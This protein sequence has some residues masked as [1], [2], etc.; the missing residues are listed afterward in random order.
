MTIKIP[1]LPGDDTWR[2]KQV[3][4]SGGKTTHVAW[5]RVLK[6]G[7]AGGYAVAQ[8]EF[9]PSDTLAFDT[10][11][12]EGLKRIERDEHRAKKEERDKEKFLE[13]QRVA[14]EHNDMKYKK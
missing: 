12:R 14:K 2:V 4:Y 11:Y 3:S 8:G 10:V 5:W 6:S 1:K 9:F 7:S 13:F